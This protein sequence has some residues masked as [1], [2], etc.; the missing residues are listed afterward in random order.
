MD[1]LEESQSVIGKSYEEMNDSDEAAMHVED[2]PSKEAE[3]RNKNVHYIEFEQFQTSVTENS[4]I[5]A[6]DARLNDVS[7]K[8]RTDKAAS[9][10]Q[11]EEGGNK[12]AE[13][14]VVVHNISAQHGE[15]FQKTEV[16]SDGA[17]L[18]DFPL[19]PIVDDP[20]GLE[21]ETT[22]EVK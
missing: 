1:E 15:I 2:G 6:S 9:T 20:E 7:A 17:P 8:E 14:E 21:E 16:L 18:E 12:E 4:A 5:E 11:L 19:Y 22:N 10:K 13:Q 3:V